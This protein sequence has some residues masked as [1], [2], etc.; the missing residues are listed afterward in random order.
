MKN[1]DVEALRTPVAVP[2]SSRAVCHRTLRGAR[3]GLAVVGRWCRSS[4]Y[5]FFH[6]FI[7]SFQLQS[8]SFESEC[9]AGNAPRR[10]PRAEPP[11]DEF[12]LTKHPLAERGCGRPGHVIPLHVLD[13][14]AALADEMVMPNAFRI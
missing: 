3:C 4:Y 2:A 9:L 11:E 14:A 6:L 13:I 12:A 10:T 5:F 1:R 7:L 8:F